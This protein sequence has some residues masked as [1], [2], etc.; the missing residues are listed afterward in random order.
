MAQAKCRFVKMPDGTY[1]RIRAT[2]IVSDE[3]LAVLQA[4]KDALE[5]GK[6]LH[7]L[8][9]EAKMPNC[10]ACKGTGINPRRGTGQKPEGEA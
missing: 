7:C 6:C 9:K 5:A 4:F 3:D 1:Q 10:P 2:G 8:G